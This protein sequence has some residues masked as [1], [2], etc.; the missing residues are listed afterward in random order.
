MSTR[1]PT[2]P[3]NILKSLFYSILGFFDSE[4]G[5]PPSAMAATLATY[6][7]DKTETSAKVVDSLEEAAAYLQREERS[8]Q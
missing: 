6:V 3:S 4:L 2:A 1:I 5:L 8:G 7:D